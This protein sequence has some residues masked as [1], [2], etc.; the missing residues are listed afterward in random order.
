MQQVHEGLTF[1]RFTLGPPP[2]VSIFQRVSAGCRRPWNGAR[3]SNRKLRPLFCCGVFVE[4]SSESGDEVYILMDK[5][6]RL[7]I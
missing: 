7:H 4:E 6:L 5:I 1:R 2:P 3:L